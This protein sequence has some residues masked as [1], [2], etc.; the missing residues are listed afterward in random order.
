MIRK[1]TASEDALV[2]K[3]VAPKGRTIN[4]IRVR[5]HYLGCGFRPVCDS[6]PRLFSE[7]TVLSILKDYFANG[8]TSRAIG[9]KYG[10]SKMYVVGLCV[11]LGI[12][13]PRPNSRARLGSYVEYDGEKY[14]WNGGEWRATRGARGSLARR[15]YQKHFGAVPKATM[16]MTRDGNPRN[17]CPENLEAVSYE[18]FGRRI[19]KNPERAEYNRTVLAIGRLIHQ[20]RKQND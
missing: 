7:D 18:E 9:A 20:T 17:L 11:R 15:I 16:I 14:V 13:S 6:R 5:S 19:A 1:W 12:K 4:A 8:L 2:R 10:C 3:G